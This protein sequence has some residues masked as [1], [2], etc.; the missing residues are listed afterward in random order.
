M[1]K[2]ISVISPVYR[3]EKILPELVKRIDE[4][5]KANK[6][7][8]EIILVDDNSPDHS[9]EVIL[10]LRKSYPSLRGF[11]LS[12][13]FGQH[14]GITAGLEKAKGDY[15]VVMDCDL[16]DNPD[17]IPKM[18]K[19][20]K[21]GNDIVCTVKKT[22]KHNLYRRI[23]SNL[24][25]IFYNFLT[26]TN[27]QKNLGGYTM[28]NRNALNGFLRVKDYHRHFSLVLSWIGYKKVYMEVE[29]DERFEGKSTY[30]FVKLIKHAM[31]GIVSQSDKLLRLSI[32]LS[33]IFVSSAILG[34]IYILYVS[35]FRTG[36]YVVGWPSVAMIILFASGL[37][38]FTL[39]I[40]GIYI[41]KIFEQVK[42]RPLY[43]ISEET[44]PEN[45]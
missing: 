18:L 3:A 34:S 38:L 36:Y 20:I 29:H 8:V 12:R 27:L 41:G 31:D 4:V 43:L 11:R 2:L 1:N 10:Q 13:N 15:A 39:G 23:T 6:L 14:Y 19:L 44:D 40:T 26:G 22:K 37:I 42:D 32:Y 28:L 33:F 25:F 24:F 35:I 5:A 30:S 17:Y 45:N 21:E 9:W 7:N 16:Q